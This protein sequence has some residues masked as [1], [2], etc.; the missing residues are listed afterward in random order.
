MEVLEQK[1]VFDVYEKIAPHFSITRGYLWNKVKEFTQSIPDISIVADIGCGNGKNSAVSNYFSFAIDLCPSF[2]KIC[3]ERGLESNCCNIVNLPYRTN[4]FDYCLCVAV[5]HHLSTEDRR[6]QAIK[7]L[8]RITK[9]GGK[10]FIQV[11]ALEQPDKS[12]KKFTKQD[13]LIQ[14]Y[15]QR[16]F[17]KEKQKDVILKR[18][19][20]V[21]K[22]GELEDICSKA[23]AY[24]ED[25]FYECGNW[26]VI[27]EV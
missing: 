18:Y 17:T 3:K 12:K 23:G 11:W 16:R 6:V 25:S 26:G 19:Y 10:I 1:Y 20:H 9:S 22:K 27:I 13:N 14:W 15:L 21:F 4:M 2:L 5:I 7:E 8:M 24:I